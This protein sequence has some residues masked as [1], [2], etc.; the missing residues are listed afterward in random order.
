MVGATDGPDWF[1]VDFDSLP[2]AWRKISG[3]D[4]REDRVFG[5]VAAEALVG[6]EGD[7][8]VAG[9]GG[10]DRLDG[11]AGAD[12]LF[13]GDGND[14][15]IGGL[16]ADLMDGDAGDDRFYSYVDRG[17]DTTSA[18]QE[19]IRRSSA[20]RGRRR[21]SPSSSRIRGW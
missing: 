9:S 2:A 14:V 7:D 8:L 21:P 10:A 4:P 12:T 19:A 5:S 15:R 3:F 16:G 1:L 18:A 17:P 6:T 13:G 20:A 11:R